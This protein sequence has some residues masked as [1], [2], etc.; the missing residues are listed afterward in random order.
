VVQF[1]VAVP[2]VITVITEPSTAKCDRVKSN[3]GKKKDSQKA[4]RL[5][6]MVHSVSG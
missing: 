1:I 4:K 2:N 5:A 3:S 6:G